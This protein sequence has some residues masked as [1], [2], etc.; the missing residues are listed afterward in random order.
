MSSFDYSAFLYGDKSTYNKQ[1]KKQTH[2]EHTHVQTHVQ[3]TSP[4]LFTLN[5]CIIVIFIRQC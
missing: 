5:T 1:T 2:I 3:K 4:S